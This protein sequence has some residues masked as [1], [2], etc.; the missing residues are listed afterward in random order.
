LN[1]GSFDATELF[2][3]SLAFC[4]KLEIGMIFG[5]FGIGCTNYN[6]FNSI[7]IVSLRQEVYLILSIGNVGVSQRRDSIS[8]WMSVR[9]FC[10][11]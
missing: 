11:V 2:A 5:V 10:W 3:I 4:L 8:S 7:T 1:T 9:T 6:I